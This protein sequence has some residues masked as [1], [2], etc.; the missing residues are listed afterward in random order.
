MSK[1][2]DLAAPSTFLGAVLHG[3]P[4]TSPF[5]APFK[6]EFAPLADLGFKAILGFSLHGLIPAPGAW[7]N[8]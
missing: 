8:T 4:V 7:S 1:G 3:I 5:L 6:R 2:L